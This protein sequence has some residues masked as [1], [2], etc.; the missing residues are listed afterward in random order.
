M[1]FPQID[2]VI[3]SIGPISL[4]WYGFM[5]LLGFVAAWLLGNYR[6]SQTLPNG[7]NRGWTKDMVAD[8]LF[9]AFLGV[10]VGGRVGYVIFYHMDLWQQDFWYLF[11]IWE[12]GM[13]FHGG[14]IGVVV[15]C[16]YFARK[17]NK[18]LFQVADFIAPL[19]PLGIMFGRLGNFINGELWGRE[20]SADFALGMR[21]PNDPLGL[22][23]HPSQLYESFFEG[24]VLFIIVWFYSAKPRPAKAVSGLFLLGYGSFRFMIEYF[25]EPDSHL[26]AVSE[27]ITRGQLLS[28]PLVAVGLFLMIV[29][30]R[31]KKENK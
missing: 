24:L 2:P 29:A 31:A 18:T 30:Y 13:S 11:K 6:A 23:R 14:L 20:A 17:N 15:A 10:I 3:F 19:A 1:D 22:I 21:F 5:Y 8:F 7:G 25:R 4:H 9:Y 16:W 28:L 27:V 26:A 12:G